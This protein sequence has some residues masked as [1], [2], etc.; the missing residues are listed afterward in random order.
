MCKK[1]SFVSFTLLF[2]L[3]LGCFEE[4]ADLSNPKTYNSNQI[5]FKYPRNWEITDDTFIPAIHNLLIETPVGR[6]SKSEFEPLSKE[7]GFEWVEENFEISILSESIPHKR[8]YGTTNIAD[9]QVFLI[10]Q[11]ASEDHSKAEPGFNLI[12][13]SLRA[14]ELK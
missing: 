3:L 4:V 5:F 14:S 6:I 13:N 7:E 9:R 1:F 10:F 11:V 2:S 8:T 12:R